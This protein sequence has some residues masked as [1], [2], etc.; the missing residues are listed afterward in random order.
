MSNEHK[1]PSKASILSAA[2]FLS[3]FPAIVSCVGAA[4]QRSPHHRR[5]HLRR[6]NPGAT[7]QTGTHPYC[8]S[9]PPARSTA[10]TRL[11]AVPGTPMPRMA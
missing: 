11:L 3:S 5:E 6:Y 1:A 10:G 7:A 8:S 2:R 9:T 4:C